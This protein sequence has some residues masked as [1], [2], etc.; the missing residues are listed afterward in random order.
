[1]YNTFP[2][3][4]LWQNEKTHKELKATAIQTIR[5][6]LD[7]KLL[8]DIKKISDNTE[9][10]CVLSK[11]CIV[12]ISI[13]CVIRVCIRFAFCHSQTQPI[14]FHDWLKLSRS[15]AI[16]LRIWLC[17]IN[18]RIDPDKMSFEGKGKLSYPKRHHALIDG[19][20]ITHMGMFDVTLSKSLSTRL[21]SGSRVIQ[22][23]AR[24]RCVVIILMLSPRY[25]LLKLNS[26]T[27][28]VYYRATVIRI[29]IYVPIS[30]RPMVLTRHQTPRG[31]SFGKGETLM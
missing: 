21:R 7:Y 2:I 23:I 30:L 11:L 31:E 9:T 27:K 16:I 6:W 19:Y 22:Q 15:E 8:N 1:M 4:I 17:R 13:K 24:M 3:W 29:Q 28:Q 12:L 18:G 20:A 10:T 25:M 5:K 14:P 26:Y